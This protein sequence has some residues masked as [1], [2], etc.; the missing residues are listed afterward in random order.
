MATGDLAN[1]DELRRAGGPQVPVTA[2][3]QHGDLTWF[4]D[5]FVTRVPGVAHTVVVSADGIML[6]KSSTL[7][8]DRAQ[9]LAA[10][11]S[12]VA[13]LSDAAARNFGAGGVVQT[14]VEMDHGFL[15]LMSMSEGACLAVLAA[16][17]CEMG[18]LAYEMSMLVEQVGERLTPELRATQGRAARTDPA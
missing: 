7:P 18:M 14:S 8:K 15:F 2:T 1:H 5:D 3:R 17:D 4:L 13:S 6:A 10:V 12:G 9:Q 11:A 16:P